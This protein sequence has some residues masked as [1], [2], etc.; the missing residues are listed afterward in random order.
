M[1]KEKMIYLTT[2]P[3]RKKDINREIVVRRPR[4]SRSRKLGRIAVD[5]H[6]LFINVNYR[7][8]VYR[9]IESQT[10]LFVLYVYH[11]TWTG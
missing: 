11:Y 1:Y 4:D 9:L 8:F 10:H 6:G 3:L 7:F 5:Y 2:I